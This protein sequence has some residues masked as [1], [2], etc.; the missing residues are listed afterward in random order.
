MNNTDIADLDRLKKFLNDNK[1]LVNNSEFGALYNKCPEY[2][3]SDLLKVLSQIDVLPINIAKDFLKNQG[4]YYKVSFRLVNEEH[5]LSELIMT[6]KLHW[7]KLTTALAYK[8]ND[9]TCKTH[10][11]R[12]RRGFRC[13]DQY[14]LDSK[15]L[16]EVAKEKQA[17]R[18]NF[19]DMLRNGNYILI[20]DFN[21][22][23]SSNIWYIDNY[24]ND[25]YNSVNDFNWYE[26]SGGEIILEGAIETFVI[27]VKIEC[28]CFY[29]NNNDLQH[30]KEFSDEYT[31][32]LTEFILEE[33]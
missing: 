32:A 17:T 4:P 10:Y 2:M 5:T 20:D 12:L 7:D 16:V 33:N 11:K 8:Y 21:K 19:M 23:I 25:V 27:P 29:Y 9:I 6:Y 3:V 14:K 15:D 1:S 13:I 30:F 28:P 26:I 22:E 24:L 31:K 18:P